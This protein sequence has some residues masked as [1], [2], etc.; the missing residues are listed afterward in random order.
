[1]MPHV[2]VY[3]HLVC[4]IPLLIVLPLLPLLFSLLPRL[5]IRPVIYFMF[6]PSFLLLLMYFPFSSYHF[7]ILVLLFFCII[8][9]FFSSSSSSRPI[10]STSHISTFLL[11]YY[12]SFVSSS[13]PPLP[14][15]PVFIMYSS[16]MTPKERTQRLQFVFTEKSGRDRALSQK[17]YLMGKYSVM[18]ATTNKNSKNPSFEGWKNNI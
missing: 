10:L 4:F 5:P 17:P 18:L 8:F 14:L 15:Y 1:M 16:N 2:C 6:V 3:P 7:S 9:V 11:H 13:C 12:F